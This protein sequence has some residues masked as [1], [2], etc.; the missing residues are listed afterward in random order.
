MS[1]VEKCLDYAS[2]HDGALP[3]FEKMDEL[4]HEQ[5]GEYLKELSGAVIPEYFD[6]P[7]ITAAY[8]LLSLWNGLTMQDIRRSCTFT[9]KRSLTALP[10]MPTLKLYAK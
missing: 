9:T 3:P 8:K 7:V 2:A 4:V 6:I 1:L 5:L 10:K